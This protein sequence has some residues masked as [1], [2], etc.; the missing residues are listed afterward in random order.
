MDGNE[1][2]LQ[3]SSWYFFCEERKKLV[4]RVRSM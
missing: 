3:T 1:G 2:Q 4:K